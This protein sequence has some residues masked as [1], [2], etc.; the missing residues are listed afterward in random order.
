[1]CPILEVTGKFGRL[2]ALVIDERYRG[3]GVGRSLLARVEA[4]ARARGCL[5]MEVTS[6]AHRDAAHRFYEA[7]GYRDSRRGA[8]RFTKFLPAPPPADP[9]D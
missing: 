8:M 7:A 1:V 6:A 5:L 2:V 3:R 4:A 9:I